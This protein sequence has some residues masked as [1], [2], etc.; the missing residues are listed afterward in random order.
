[1]K[2]FKTRSC[3]FT[4]H[5]LLLLCFMGS[6][7]VVYRQRFHHSVMKFGR[8]S[9]WVS[10]WN[11]AVDDHKKNDCFRLQLHQTFFT[12]QRC[13]F[14][15]GWR[16]LLPYLVIFGDYL[17][18]LPVK[19]HRR[20]LL[21]IR[22]WRANTRGRWNKGKKKSNECWQVKIQTLTAVLCVSVCSR[23]SGLLHK[24][25]FVSVIFQSLSK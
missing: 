3:T 24:V 25:K 12:M 13:M 16:Q 5:M 4:H 23:V 9:A 2:M 10:G 20:V 18:P 19:F 6:K 17:S 1:M 8:V 22:R 21:S 14:T 11:L 7:P 15:A